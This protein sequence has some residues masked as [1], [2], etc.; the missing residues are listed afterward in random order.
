M[1]PS[2]YD[3][4]Y[5]LEDI[6]WWCVG[7]RRVAWALL[8]GV[9]LP[10]GARVLDLGCGTGAFLRELQ[11]RWP[12]VGVDLS[13]IALG[14]CGARRLA[15]LVQ[16]SADHLP[17]PA[18][19]FGLVTCMDVLYHRAVDEAAALRE[20]WRVLAPGGWLLVRVPAYRWLWSRHDLAEHAA[21][22]YTA[23]GLAGSLRAAGFAVRR[24]TYANTLLFPLAAGKRLLH[25]A[26]DGSPRCDLQPLPP[27][28]NTL[29]QCV[30]Q[31]EAWWLR[32][33]AFPFGLS[34]LALVQKPL[35]S[36]EG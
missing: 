25:R 6:H 34:V 3:I 29:L 17:F 35:H 26:A 9:S 12:A 27:A 16:A 14:Y 5:Q 18:A 15:G 23:R 2:A 32:R 13:A 33:R 21:R 7:M 4:L 1:E 36:A 11:K 8:E 10:P 20:V 31:V 28:A 24:L 19:S 30:L 22:R